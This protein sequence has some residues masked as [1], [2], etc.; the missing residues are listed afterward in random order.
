MEDKTYYNIPDWLKVL[1]L[2]QA[3]YFMN[4]IVQFNIEQLKK[5]LKYHV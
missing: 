2:L 4:Q 5:D 1:H 3:E